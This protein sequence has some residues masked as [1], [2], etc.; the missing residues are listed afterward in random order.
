MISFKIYFGYFCWFLSSIQQV[1]QGFGAGEEH[2]Y[3][4]KIYKVLSKYLEIHV[5]KNTF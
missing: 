3:Y 5:Q 4:H 1:R 2:N